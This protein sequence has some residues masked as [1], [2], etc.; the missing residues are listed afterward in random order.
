[1]G[2][3]RERWHAEAEK[4]LDPSVM[5]LFSRRGAN[6]GTPVTNPLSEQTMLISEATPVDNADADEFIKQVRWCLVGF[7]KGVWWSHG[8]GAADFGAAH[9]DGIA[10]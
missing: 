9:R 8:N 3:R 2:I 6:D 4:F 7:V 5:L 10:L 1:M